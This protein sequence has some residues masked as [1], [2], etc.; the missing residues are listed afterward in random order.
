MPVPLTIQQGDGSTQEIDSDDFDWMPDGQSL[1]FSTGTAISR[2]NKDGSG[3]VPL[4]PATH[5]ICP[6]GKVI[7]PEGKEDGPSDTEYVLPTVSPN[8]QSIIAYVYKDVATATD[9]NGNCTNISQT[10]SWGVRSTAGGAFTLEAISGSGLPPAY[11]ADWQAI[12][13]ALTVNIFDGYDD[14][15]KGMK[16]ELLDSGGNVIDDQPVNSI[17]GSYVFAD[18]P[19]P[20][21][22]TIRATLI[23][24]CAAPCT[25][26]F[27]IRYAPTPA[28]PVWAEWGITIQST[29]PPT[30]TL[31]FAESD[32]RL[33][34]SN[35]T[36]K[37][38]LDDM[39]AIY[40]RTRQYVDWVESNLTINTGPTAHFYTFATQDPSGGPLPAGC[41]GSKGQTDCSYYSRATSQIVLDTINSN[42]LI[43]KGL[44][45]QYNDAPLNVEW[46]EYTHHLYENFVNDGSCPGDQNH[47]GYNNPDS[48]DSMNEGFASF[49]P[50]YAARDI[51]GASNGHYANIWDLQA[52]TKVWGYREGGYNL[53]D[54]SVAALFWDLTA[55][56]GNTETMQVVGAD[57]NLH[58]VTLTNS[59]TNLSIQ[60]LWAQ[61]TSA[62][63]ATVFALRQL[64][65]F[66]NPTIDLDGDGVPDSGILG[67]GGDQHRRP[68]DHHLFRYGQ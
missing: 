37:D 9:A 43:R 62:K 23:D 64:L 16:V 50:T 42:Y 24:N 49:L 19:A 12:P 52:P 36:N 60:Q 28:D 61:L 7:G 35:P 2:V 48:C 10:S 11:R 8:G 21:D 59:V 6:S 30:F 55:R 65:G 57:G 14:P 51:L 40:F 5:N 33:G 17:G 44:N 58:A 15:L 53:E 31:N 26:A 68:D 38:P 47:F 22:Y 34:N 41:T 56:N 27:D 20:G 18:T 32:I 45:V 54:L 13:Q 29:Q 4:T 67:D 39:A 66:P 25:P 46:H 3:L 63:P 1:V